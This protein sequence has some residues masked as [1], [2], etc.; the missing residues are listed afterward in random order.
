MAAPALQKRA[1]KLLRRPEHGG[2]ILDARG[3]TPAD[4]LI[5]ALSDQLRRPVDLDEL[6]ALGALEVDQ[7]MVRATPRR[8]DPRFPDILYHATTT[9]RLAR[10]RGQ[11]FVAAGRGRRVFLSADPSATWGVAHRLDRGEPT[12]LVIDAARAR[13]A[14]VRI[15]RGRGGLYL[16][17][18]VPMRFVLNLR[19]GYAEQHSAGGFLMRDRGFGPELALVS[20][21]RRSGT[22]WEIAKGKLEAG[23]SPEQAAVREVREEMGLAATPEILRAL[24]VV[25]YGFQTPEGQPRLKSMFV[26]LMKLDPAPDRFRPAEGEGIG[27]VRWFPVSEASRLVQHPSLVQILGELQRIL[28]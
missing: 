16:A 22:T 1:L 8:R 11:G 25:R 7:G 3:W 23:E 18:R 24:G 12:V 28:P 6:A 10:F 26:Y 27:E 4:G 19:K 17:P 9:D 5:G 13:R 20:C 21:T 14:R 15:S 2:L